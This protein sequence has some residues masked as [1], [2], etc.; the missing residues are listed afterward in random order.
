MSIGSGK[1]R[2]RKIHTFNDKKTAKKCIRQMEVALDQGTNFE[3][4]NWK[5]IEYYKYWID[6][7][8]K[9]LVSSDTS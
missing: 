7:Y 2:K 9:P 8:K 4:T 5:F 1:E 3:K 6:L